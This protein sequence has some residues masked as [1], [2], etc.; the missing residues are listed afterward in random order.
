MSARGGRGRGGGAS[1]GGGRGRKGPAIKDDDKSL[2]VVFRVGID[3]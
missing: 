1:G 2:G 3:P